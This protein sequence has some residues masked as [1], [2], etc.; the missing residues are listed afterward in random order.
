VLFDG[1]CTM[2]DIFLRFLY[3]WDSQANL[4]YGSQQSVAGRKIMA[5]HNLPQDLRSVWLLEESEEGVSAYSE[6][7]AVLRMF[8]YLSYPWCLF[9][10]F[11]ALPQFIRDFVYRVVARSRYHVLGKKSHATACS[12]VPGMRS[13]M[14][15]LRVSSDTRLEIKC[16]DTHSSD[17]ATAC[18]VRWRGL[19]II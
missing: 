12:Y 4:T 18:S 7:T 15:D 2:C 10:V 1:V 11:I 6:S 8:S 19:E 5:E 3:T 14:L 13:R 16:G 17:A 9:Y